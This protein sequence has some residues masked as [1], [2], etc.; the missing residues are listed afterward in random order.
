LQ[1]S[2]SATVQL[3]L[4]VFTALVALGLVPLLLMT[5]NRFMGGSIFSPVKTPTALAT[6]VAAAGWA[7]VWV[8]L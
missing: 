2:W 8:L 4:L 3:V 1:D 7:R 6:Q 5:T